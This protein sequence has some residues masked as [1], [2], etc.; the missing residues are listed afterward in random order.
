MTTQDS[1]GSVFRNTKDDRQLKTPK[2]ENIFIIFTVPIVT[3]GSLF[4]HDS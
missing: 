1:D 2:Y 4:N 3:I